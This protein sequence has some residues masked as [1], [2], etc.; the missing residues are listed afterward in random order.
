[1]PNQAEST[2]ANRLCK[3]CGRRLSTYNPGERCFTHAVKDKTRNI[4]AEEAFQPAEYLDSSSF[5]S[6]G[7]PRLRFAEGSSRVLALA[8]SE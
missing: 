8:S 4:P 7:R 1:M 3:K 5:F 6:D 2:G